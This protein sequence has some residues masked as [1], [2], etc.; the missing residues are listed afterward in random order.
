MRKSE[1]LS[2]T[3]K[4][5]QSAA[6]I[7]RNKQYM[8]ETIYGSDRWTAKPWLGHVP[9]L[10]EGVEKEESSRA[11]SLAIVMTS[12]IAGDYQRIQDKKKTQRETTV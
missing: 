8:H 7:E 6:M 9:P 10:P 1:R 12:R 3:N 11:H 4:K 2:R 5:D